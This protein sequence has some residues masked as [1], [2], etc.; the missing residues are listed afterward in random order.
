MVATTLPFWM[1]HSHRTMVPFQADPMLRAAT[2]SCRSPRAAAP[3]PGALI[4]ELCEGLGIEEHVPAWAAL[5]AR[6]VEPNAFLEPGFAL[7]AVMHFPQAQRPRF[8]LCW[9]GEA[10]DPPTLIGLLALQASR[11]LLTSVGEAWRNPQW[12]VS[13]PLLDA[14]RGA[15]AL[16][17]MLGWLAADHRTRGGLLV[18]GVQ[19]GGPLMRLLEDGGRRRV[20]LLE[21]RTRAMLDG[22]PASAGPGPKRLK[23]LRRQGRRLGSPVLRSWTSVEAVRGATER[24]LELEARGWKGTRGTAL[25]ADA[26]LSTFTRTMLRLM[27]AQGLC[28]ID[29]LEVDGEPVA[30]GV[31]LKSQDRA[32]YWKTAYD[33]AH[34]RHSPG[35]LLALA[36]AE[37]QRYDRATS[38]TDSCAVPDHPMIDGIWTGRMEVADLLVACPGEDGTRFARAAAQL[39][40]HTAARRQAKAAY[41]GLRSAVSRLLHRGGWKGR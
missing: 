4:V 6:A 9:D 33:E 29:A 40:L 41:H 8:L 13:A 34:A 11:P 36:M 35:K 16:D 20:A 15:A 12:V 18:R 38:L 14:E 1:Q 37:R 27:A 21:T 5:A 10:A 3:R 7:P 28:R 39:R 17:A 23:E 25:L 32:F 19:K 24:F 30:M 2:A 26:H 22:S 31:V